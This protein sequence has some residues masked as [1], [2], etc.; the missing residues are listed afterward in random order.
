MPDEGAVQTLS[1]TSTQVAQVRTLL[2]RDS[3]FRLER[4]TADPFEVH[5]SVN[6]SSPLNGTVVTC[7]N[8]FTNVEDAKMSTLSIIGTT[9]LCVFVE[10]LIV[11]F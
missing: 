10:F 5:L 2:V 9:Y 3:T 1:L 8:D 11:V 7:S 4:I 6:A